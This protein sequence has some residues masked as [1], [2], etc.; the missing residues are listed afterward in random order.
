MNDKIIFQ[1]SMPTRFIELNKKE[2]RPDYYLRDTV[3]VSIP[4]YDDVVAMAPM[5]AQKR[6]E[7]CITHLANLDGEDFDEVSPADGMRLLNT[8]TDIVVEINNES[9]SQQE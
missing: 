9:L 3:E 8:I 7:Y 5:N 4:D 2:N 6:M 1:L